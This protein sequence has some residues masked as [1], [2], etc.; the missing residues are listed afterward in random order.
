MYNPTYSRISIKNPTDNLRLSFGMVSLAFL[1]LK[2]LM[3]KKV[4]IMN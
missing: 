4:E 3:P 1:L 2:L